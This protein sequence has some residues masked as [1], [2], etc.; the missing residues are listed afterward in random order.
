MSESLAE[1]RD[2][3]PGSTP[4]PGTAEGQ[5]RDRLSELMTLNELAIALSTSLEEATIVDRALEAIVKHLPFERALIILADESRRVLA[6]A[7][8]IGGSA[9][10]GELIGAAEISLDDTD[11]QLVE[12]YGSDG[13]LVYRDVDSDPHPDNRAL[14]AALGVTSYL[15][16]PLVIQ[17][18]S[19]GVLA[20]DNGLS[21]REVRPS[22]GPLL[23]TLGSLV[24]AALENA[25]LYAEVEGQKAELERRV[26]QR[27]E[28]LARAIEEAHAAR[29]TAEA[30]SAVKSQ[31]LS[32][33]SHE[34]RTPLTSVIGFTKLVRKR[35]DE[36]ILPVVPAEATDDPKVER[37]IRQVGQNLGIMV[38]EGERL[39]NLIN[40]VLDLAKIEAG[41]FEWRTGP[42]DVGEVVERATGATAALFEQSGLALEVDVA[43][44]LPSIEGD[45]DRLIQ[46]VI[47][48]LSNAVKFTPAPGSVAV[49][50]R[51]SDGSIEVAV[52]DSGVGIA[53][54]DQERI[55]E[56]FGQARDTLSETPRGTGLGLPI[57]REIVEHHGGRIWLES[58]PGRGST[59]RFTL[60]IGAGD[61]A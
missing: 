17:G 42:V 29:A 26:V 49:R 3:A 35:L 9:E 30:A 2:G 4:G 1:R 59:F 55:W 31:F 28:A 20:V 39:T 56:Q 15:G 54:E 25:R 53:P 47:N 43:A 37:A 21:G 44:G 16:T 36:V 57:C 45:R 27:T 8:S 38:A 18:R 13:P 5:L 23:Y 46:V 41:K 50:A 6:G 22:D 48:L 19:L 7:R 60:P 33:V 52:S 58:E 10:L 51:R 12:I 40:D 32:N 14:A 24:A 11:A 61:A 34:L